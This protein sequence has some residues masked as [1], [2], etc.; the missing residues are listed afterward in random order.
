[1]SVGPF[2]DHVVN[3][4]VHHAK[5]EHDAAI[6]ELEPVVARGFIIDKIMRGYEL[7]GCYYETGQNEKAI[8]VLQKTQKLYSHMLPF[9]RAAVYPRSHYLL[10]KIYE[11]KGDEKLAIASFEKFLSL[12]KAADKDLPESVDAKQR[13]AK[14]RR[15]HL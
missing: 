13:L 14:L 7:A 1:M 15:A 8:E 3:G 6:K 12:W 5:G 4:H 10:G 2:A 11:Q 9:Y